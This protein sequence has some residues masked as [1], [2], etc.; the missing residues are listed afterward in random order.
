M[1]LK[2]SMGMHEKVSLGC[3]N[4][5]AEIV[6]K[7]VFKTSTLAPGRVLV[8]SSRKASKKGKK[9]KDAEAAEDAEAAK[10]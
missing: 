9:G 6:N 7:E 3:M 2:N 8:T 5:A 1:R 4:A 10:A